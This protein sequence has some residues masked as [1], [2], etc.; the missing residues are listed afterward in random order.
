MCS[1]EKGATIELLFG[2]GARGGGH[3]WCEREHRHATS[4]LATKGTKDSRLAFLCTCGAS[5]QELTNKFAYFGDIQEIK[6]LKAPRTGEPRGIAYVKYHKTSTAMRAV[7]DI[8]EQ[9]CAPAALVH[10]RGR[11]VKGE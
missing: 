3:R 9:E 4:S 6:V 1:T 8:T 5:T 10:A 7:E 11:K 2:K